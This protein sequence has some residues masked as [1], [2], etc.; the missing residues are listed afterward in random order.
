M[1]SNLPIAVRNLRRIWNDKKEEL[2]IDQSDAAKKLNWTQGA[3]SQYLNNITSLNSDAIVKLANFF[4][5]S[6]KEIDPEFDDYQYADMNVPFMFSSPNININEKM[7]FKRPE[8][9]Y[10]SQVLIP[11]DVNI[12]D[13]APKGTFIWAAKTNKN[14]AL[15]NSSHR[16]IAPKGKLN[17]TEFTTGT[18]YFVVRK[19]SEKGEIID[20]PNLPPEKEIAI[21]YTVLAVVYV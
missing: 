15:N 9:V 19:N 12:K 11:V 3:F 10:D 13:F 16:A 8:A 5:V 1:S 14:K 4:E 20:E 2:N 17:L 7:R 21:I 18:K 6:P